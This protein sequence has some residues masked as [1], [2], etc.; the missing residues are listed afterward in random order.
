MAERKKKKRNKPH[1][2]VNVAKDLVGDIIEDAALKYVGKRTEAD[3]V[4]IFEGKDLKDRKIPYPTRKGPPPRKRKAVSR[5]R[6]RKSNDP[7]YYK[8]FARKKPR[9]YTPPV[10]NR[11]YRR[12]MQQAPPLRRFRPYRRNPPRFLPVVHARPT[13]T[14][15]RLIHAAE[16]RFAFNRRLRSIYHSR[17]PLFAS[18]NLWKAYR[19]TRRDRLRNE[20]SYIGISCNSY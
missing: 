18:R 5:S 1:G 13:S 4:R 2:F 14:E 19:R 7:D 10:Q 17:L 16:D 12:P 8:N 6:K 20:L 3:I 15:N 11:P 9:S